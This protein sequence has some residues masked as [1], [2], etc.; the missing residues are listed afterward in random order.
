MIENEIDFLKVEHSTTII[1]YGEENG[2]KYWIGMN[3]WGN[4]WGEN[5]FY[6]ILRGEN[7][8][9][10]ETMGDY[11]NIEITDRKNNNNNN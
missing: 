1:G 2:V 6:K 3:T 8:M 10:I 5:G 7:E 9:N 11:F 4:D